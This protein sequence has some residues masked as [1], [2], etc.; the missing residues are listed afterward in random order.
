M[1]LEFDFTPL[2]VLIACEYSGTV[3]DAFLAEGHDAWSCDILADDTGSNRHIRDDVR[4]HLTGWDLIIVAHPPCTRLCNSGVRWLTEAPKRLNPEHHTAA[5]VAAYARMT[6]AQRLAFMWAKLDEGA[7]L[8]SDLWNAPCDRVVCENPVMH[9]HAKARI[10]NYAEPVQSIQPWQFGD[11][12]TKRTHFWARGV[13]PL[14]PLYPKLDDARRALGLPADAKPVTRVHSMA[15]GP[16]RSK[17]RSR[18]FPS[19][20]REMARQWGAQSM[21]QINQAKA[22]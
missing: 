1:Q 21:Q 11:W 7:A 20:A 18:F 8:F 2:K 14:A 22:A 4:N 19:V 3:R 10:R 16:E 9:R 12:E 5:E 13:A 17:E 6:D 15:P